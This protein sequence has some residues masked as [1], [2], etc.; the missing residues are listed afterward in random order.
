VIP[1][2][3]ARRWTK[4]PSRQDKFIIDKNMTQFWLILYGISQHRNNLIDWSFVVVFRYHISS[5]H[6]SC[7]TIEL[8]LQGKEVG[9]ECLAVRGNLGQFTR[10]NVS[11]ILSV[12]SLQCPCYHERRPFPSTQPPRLSP[13]P[14]E[15]LRKLIVL[16]LLNT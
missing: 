15:Y 1:F 4:F 2:H 11:S 14:C 7:G 10:D 6:C 12:L 3:Q 16:Q 5:R 13:K 8:K 9:G